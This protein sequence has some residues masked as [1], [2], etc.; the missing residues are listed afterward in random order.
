MQRTEII[1]G[2]ID[3]NGYQSYLEIGLGNGLNFK[4]IRVANKLGVDP[5]V[6]E[7]DNIMAATSDNF[8]LT[9]KEF[10]LSRTFDIIFIDGLH[11]SDQVER[12]IVNSYEVLNKGGVILLHDCVPWEEIISRVPR[13]TETWTGDVYRAVCGFYDVYR[14]KL[15][16]KFFEERTGIVAI[17]DDDEVNVVG[18]FNKPDLSYEKF[19]RE[20]KDKIMGL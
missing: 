16:M 18:G 10:G 13:V 5:A 1:Q 2:L 19:V 15:K 11:H 12:D 20:Y 4:N 3:A 8:F 9:R 17:F 7:T 14:D 6:K